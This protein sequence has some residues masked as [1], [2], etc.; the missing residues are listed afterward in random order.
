MEKTAT[1]GKVKVLVMDDEELIR[2][3]VGESLSY[4]GYQCEFAE[5]GDKAI[6][7]YKGAMESGEPFRVVIMDLTIPEGKGGKEA[8]GD[9]IEVDPDVAVIIS[10]GYSGDPVMAEFEK[11]GFKGVLSK[12]YK[13][14]QL[15]KLMYSII[16]R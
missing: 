1:S 12:P 9:L 5:D 6:A 3:L 10:S 2:T 7:L 15:D 11:Y 13:I 14:E 16:G 8:I 4:L